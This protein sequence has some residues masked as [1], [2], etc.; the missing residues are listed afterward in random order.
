MFT[1]ADAERIARVPPATTDME[2]PS[3]PVSFDPWE[4][5]DSPPP[6]TDDPLL[7]ELYD[8]TE[9]LDFVGDS[10]SR[11]ENGENLGNL[12]VEL[13]AT[14]ADAHASLEPYRA[15]VRAWAVEGGGVTADEDVSDLGDEAWKIVG[16]GHGLR[17]TYK[18][19]CSNLVIELHTD[20]A[21]CPP[22][23]DASTRDWVD[24][25]DEE[26]RSEG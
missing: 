6:E 7:A 24:A 15:Y 16:G 13:W 14:E 18:W 25:I 26:A 9:A 8:R 20:C 4:E 3:D 10:S 22:D 12:G 2:W 11:W 5:D 17:V 1:G 21:I 19:R 23:L